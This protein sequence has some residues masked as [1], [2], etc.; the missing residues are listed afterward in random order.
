MQFTR[1]EERNSRMKTDVAIIDIGSNSVRLMLLADGFSFQKLLAT[2]RLGEGLAQSVYLKSEAIERTARA[3]EKFVNMAREQGA[4]TICAYATASVRS[5]K[6]GGDFCRRVK[7]LCGIA[8]EVLSGKEEAE[9][10]LLGA[11]SKEDG[12]LIDVGGGST[13]IVVRKDGKIVYEK[14]VDVGVVRL[15][16]LCGRN[17]EALEEYIKGKIEEFGEV[18][19]ASFYA[20][21]GTATSLMARE[22]NL[23]QYDPSALEGRTI[24][25]TRMEKMKK[26][27]L[28]LSLDEIESP[29]IPRQRAE[30]LGGGCCL[31]C[32]I[33]KKYDIPSLTIKDSDNLE[34]YARKKNWIK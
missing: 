10:G 12:G 21:G 8:V 31:L 15:F 30:V 9:L 4:T 16:D 5:A 27:L 13:E 34:G 24:S 28:T 2:T 23:Q 14:S 18:P 29:C 19:K 32:G 20:I 7:E 1:T 3:V 26:E 33:M 6:N 25:F 22:L 11:L 17:Q